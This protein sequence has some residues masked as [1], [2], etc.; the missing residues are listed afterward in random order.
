MTLE[1][2]YRNDDSDD[3][4]DDLQVVKQSPPAP[5]VSLNSSSAPSGRERGRGSQQ[6]YSSLHHQIQSIFATEIL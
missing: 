5:F 4:D 2:D 6:K 3:D 1:N